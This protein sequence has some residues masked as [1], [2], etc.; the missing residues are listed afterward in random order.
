MTVEPSGRS[1]ARPGAP[2][3]GTDAAR[4]ANLPADPATPTD[5]TERHLP[6][7]QGETALTVPEE[8]IRVTEWRQP[9]GAGLLPLALATFLLIAFAM[10]AWTFLVAT[11]G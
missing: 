5:A 1:E 7:R 6:A 2:A 9:I 3:E 11:G 8:G 4:T 10:A